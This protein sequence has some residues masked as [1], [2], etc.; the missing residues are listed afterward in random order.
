MAGKGKW[1]ISIFLELLSR[2]FLRE[3]QKIQR[4]VQTMDSTFKRFGA[5]LKSMVAFGAITI[6]ARGITQGVT[7]LFQLNQEARNVKI[8]FEA[9]ADP[10]LL[11]AMQE[12]TQLMVKDLEL[13]KQAVMFI[14][15]G[16]SQ[17]DL[18]K[19]FAFAQ[20]RAQ[21]T[22]ESVEFMVRSLVVGLGRKSIKVLD[23]LQIDVAK[24]QEAVRGGQTFVEALGDAIDE[25][26]GKGGELIENRAL[27]MEV[28]WNNF[29]LAVSRFTEGPGEA[30]AEW[31]TETLSLMT[32]MIKIQ[33]LTGFPAIKEAE[34]EMK[35]LI[36][37]GPRLQE[38]A[39]N[40]KKFGT[41]LGTG[42]APPLISKTAEELTEGYR[43]V[44]VNLE[45]IHALE[46]KIHELRFGK[47]TAAEEDEVE[48]AAQ[49]A[50]RFK[51]FSEEE[52]KRR[53]AMKLAQGKI[54]TDASIEAFRGFT[55]EEWEESAEEVWAS[56]LD[57]R[58][59]QIRK[60][61][62]RGRTDTDVENIMGELTEES[63]DKLTEAT[64]EW[65]NALEGV[66]NTLL[67]MRSLSKMTFKD[68]IFFAL[69]IAGLLSGTG[70]AGG[71]ISS[72]I[73]GKAG[74]GMAQGLTMVGESGPELVNFANPSRVFSNPASRRM[75]G[76]GGGSGGLTGSVTFHIAGDQLV[77]V[78][79][80]TAT[81]N[82]RF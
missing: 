57:A 39:E 33:E 67:S 30:F 65:N 72:L 42:G 29:G 38:E 35:R 4:G 15:F 80:N 41:S 73:K 62:E 78:L 54:D 12:S 23:N 28:A 75:L 40:F 25:E 2:G 7:R 34:A 79:S 13:M 46:V 56:L 50:A 19:Y 66:I 20:K 37:L 32:E 49:L 64:D 68:W 17:A 51:R 59:D 3:S 71:F 1:N 47:P 53:A 76:V 74:G 11:Q 16:L 10:G 21:Q 5:T 31:M 36:A 55:Q 6:L 70:S 77:G 45:K 43:A 27:Q 18:P 8:A 61:G 60:L 63:I 48:T 81:K 82:D 14:N 58:A 9:L 22:G 24:F 69:N 52:V 44:V 26:M